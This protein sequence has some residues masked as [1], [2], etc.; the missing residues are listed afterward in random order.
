LSQGLV[1]LPLLAFVFGSLVV[2]AVAMVLRS[3]SAP[4]S[5]SASA[6]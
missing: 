3:G 4:P 6:K 2:A 5:S 1:L